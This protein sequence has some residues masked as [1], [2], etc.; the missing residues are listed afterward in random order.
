[1]ARRLWF[2]EVRLWRLKPEA[3]WEGVPGLMALYPLCRHQ[4]SPRKAIRHSAE[5]I[6]H[7]ALPEGEESRWLHVAEKQAFATPANWGVPDAAIIEP[8]C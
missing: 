4:R 5:A 2:R 6:E 8:Q 3:W 7:L 1:V